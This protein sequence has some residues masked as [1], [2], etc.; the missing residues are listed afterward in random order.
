[1]CLQPGCGANETLGSARGC[2][3]DL[4]TAEMLTPG[5]NL[6]ARNAF[7]FSSFAISSMGVPVSARRM[8][9]PANEGCPQ[10]YNSQGESCLP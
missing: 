9:A 5:S 3:P 4:S 2:Q 10:G 1:M 8:N 6:S 7:R